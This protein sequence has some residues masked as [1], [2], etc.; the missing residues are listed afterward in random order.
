MFSGYVLY[1][2]FF[3]CYLD[4]RQYQYHLHDLNPDLR[5]LRVCLFNCSLLSVLFVQDFV[6]LLS[7]SYYNELLLL[8]SYPEHMLRVSL[9]DRPVSDV[10]RKPFW[11]KKHLLNCLVKVVKML[12]HKCSLH[13][14]LPKLLK[15]FYFMQNSVALAT[16]IENYKNPFEQS[17]EIC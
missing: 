3:T 8:F 17:S 5:V 13:E 10:S 15:E 2:D 6:D 9:W 16:R 7:L 12:Q 4:T 11:F 14:V 1:L